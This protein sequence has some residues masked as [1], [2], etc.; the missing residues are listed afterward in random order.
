[1][2]KWLVIL[3][4]FLCCSCGRGKYYVS[5]TFRY[6]VPGDIQY[7]YLDSSYQFYL[8]QVYKDKDENDQNILRSNVSKT[9]TANKI[10]IEVEFLLISLLH[11]NVIYITTVP[12]KF[13]QYYSTHILPDTV[14]NAYDFNTFHFGK[15]SDDGESASFV[16]E[17]ATRKVTWQLKPSAGEP[18]PKQITL[19]ELQIEKRD[20]LTDVILVNRT[21]QEPVVFTKQQSHVIIFQKPTDKDS[22]IKCRLLYNNIYFR[23]NK[24]GTALYFRFNCNINANDSTI[25]FTHK[26]TIYNPLPLTTS[27]PK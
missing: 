18:L 11:K 8:R 1:M 25:S 22:S 5:S 12:D 4:L 20:V 3:L 2:N 23:E 27:L 14:I 19:R 21:L 7:I 24:K 6:G 15:L 9:D 13:Q 26:R 10:R 16:S 17:K